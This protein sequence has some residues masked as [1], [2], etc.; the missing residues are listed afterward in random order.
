MDAQNHHHQQQ[1]HHHQQHHQQKQQQQ[2]SQMIQ[3]QPSELLLQPQQLAL[4]EVPGVSSRLG[5]PCTSQAEQQGA[6][7]ARLKRR[8]PPITLL[9]QP[10]AQRTSSA[11]PTY[12][13]QQQQEEV[14]LSGQGAVCASG[15]GWSFGQVEA[16][17]PGDDPLAAAPQV[18]PALRL[19]DSQGQEGWWSTAG[20]SMGQVHGLHIGGGMCERRCSSGRRSISGSAAASM[21]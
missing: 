13:S 8:L 16:V 14:E 12:S 6:A 19:H 21:F 18:P 7:R 4:Q 9:Q 2:H 17:A 5:P 11:V 20:G 3:T 10:S 1:Q 15:A